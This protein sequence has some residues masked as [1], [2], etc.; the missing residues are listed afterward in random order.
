MAHGAR[1]TDQCR[2]TRCVLIAA[3]H[4]DS[5][6]CGKLPD[7]RRNRIAASD[8]QGPR[9]VV[10]GITLNDRPIAADHQKLSDVSV[11]FGLN[12]TLL[13]C[14]LRRG[15]NQ[16]DEV[17]LKRRERLLRSK[18][19]GL[20][21]LRKVRERGMHG[22]HAEAFGIRRQKQAQQIKVTQN[23]AKVSFLVL[24][25]HTAHLRFQHAAVRGEECVGGRDLDHLAAADHARVGAHIGEQQRQ[26]QLRLFEH[27]FRALG[28]FPASRGGRAGF[29]ARSAKQCGVS[30]RR[31]DRVGVG[32]LVTDDKKRRHGSRCGFGEFEMVFS[33]N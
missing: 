18:A 30:D 14:A 2:S 19:L 8:E 31:A 29:L 4:E 20:E 16:Q 11:L 15:A 1:A 27:P 13:D 3:Q 12:Q 24:D 28:N 10:D 25:R 26:F 5:A 6:R 23:P 21:R 32:I 7:L 33:V 22:T 17:L 9:A